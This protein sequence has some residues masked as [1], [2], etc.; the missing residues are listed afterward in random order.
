M[1]IGDLLVRD[2]RPGGALNRTPHV[3]LKAVKQFHC[4]P[5]AQSSYGSSFGIKQ[6][7]TQVAAGTEKGKGK[8]RQVVLDF[9][10]P[11][12]DGL[13]AVALVQLAI[14]VRSHNPGARQ[15]NP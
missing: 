6:E 13:L 15:I 2:L 12:D 7:Q 8:T 5:D 3:R 11:H 4:H 1:L 10:P 14:F 9:M